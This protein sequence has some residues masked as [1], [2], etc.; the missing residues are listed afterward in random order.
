MAD[1]CWAFF[2]Q[3]STHGQKEASSAFDLEKQTT[4][5]E[6][7][8]IKSSRKETIGNLNSQK[9]LTKKVVKDLPL[10]FFPLKRSQWLFGV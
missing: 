7:E 10:S 5:G 6:I 3:L 2:N 8:T 4:E 9:G 1:V